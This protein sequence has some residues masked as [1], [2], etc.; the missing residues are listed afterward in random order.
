MKCNSNT[1]Q[2]RRQHAKLHAFMRFS[3]CAWMCLCC[4]VL[5]WCLAVAALYILQYTSVHINAHISTHHYTSV[6]THQNNINAHTTAHQY[7]YL[8]TSQCPHQYKHQYTY[9]STHTSAHTSAHINAH[10]SFS[11]LISHKKNRLL[12]ESIGGPAPQTPLGGQA[13]QTPLLCLS[14]KRREKSTW[15]GYLSISRHIDAH[16]YTYQY[17]SQCTH[18]YIRNP[19]GIHQESIRNP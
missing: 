9:P 2:I 18:Q 1:A 16:Q 19:S 5:F 14:E 11:H 7:T 15:P 4:V 8:Y 17:T 10:I 3:D 6:S 13:P 12:A